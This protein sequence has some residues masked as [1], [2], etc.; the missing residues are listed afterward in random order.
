MAR[1]CRQLRASS[2]AFALVALVGCSQPDIPL[3]EVTG[4]VTFN[5]RSTPA[6][7]FFQPE[8]AQGQL[9][10]RPSTA[11]ADDDGEF[12]LAFTGDRSGAVIGRHR[13]LLKILRRRDGR[14]PRSYNEA[15]APLKTVQL[16]REVKP[17]RNDFRFAITY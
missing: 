14:E 8:D 10:G 3:A 4:H 7:I 1:A 2:A 5:G 12:R 11:L 17:G 9:A 15:V 16:Q 6:E 13:I